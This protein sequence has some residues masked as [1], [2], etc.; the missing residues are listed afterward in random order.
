[1]D[2]IAR[3]FHML[4][5]LHT[6]TRRDLGLFFFVVDSADVSLDNVE[7]NIEDEMFDKAQWVHSHSRL[8]LRV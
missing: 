2:S 7:L 5:K 1:M 8:S 4:W 3:L 6:D